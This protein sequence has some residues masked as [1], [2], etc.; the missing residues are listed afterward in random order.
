MGDRVDTGVTIVQMRPSVNL[1]ST[2]IENVVAKMQRS[3]LE[4]LKLLTDQMRFAGVPAV[5]LRPLDD[6]RAEARTAHPICLVP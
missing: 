3:K 4:L 6:T 5:A 2:T 1:M